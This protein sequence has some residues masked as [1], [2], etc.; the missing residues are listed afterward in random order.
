[1]VRGAGIGRFGED[2]N[3]GFVL[4]AVFAEVGSVAGMPIGIVEE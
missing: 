1:M 4:V 3:V 2:L